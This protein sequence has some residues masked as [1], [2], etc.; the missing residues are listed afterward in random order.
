MQRR[1]FGM[2]P[3]LV[4]YSGHIYHISYHTYLTPFLVFGHVSFRDATKKQHGLW[5]YIRL[6]KALSITPFSDS[7]PGLMTLTTKYSPPHNLNTLEGPNKTHQLGGRFP[8]WVLSAFLEL[9][10]HVICLM[11]MKFIVAT[12]VASPWSIT[13]LPQVGLL[14]GICT[15]TYVLARA[16]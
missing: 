6:H 13:T 10:S 16:Y 9:T 3:Q 5:L 4:L 11:V 12:T 15:I 2:F 7:S 1:Y 8:F 14:H